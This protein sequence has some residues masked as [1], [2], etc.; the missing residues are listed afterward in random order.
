MSQRRIRWLGMIA[1]LAL[2]PAAWAQAP[3]IPGAPAAPAGIAAPTGAAPPAGGGGNL[4]SFFC[5]TPEQKANCKNCFCNS[6]LGQMASGFAGPMAAMSGGLMPNWCMQNSLANDL[7][8]PADSP[9]GAAAQVK[10]DEAEAQE[11][12]AVAYLGTVDCERWPEA[13]EALKNALRKDRSECVRFAAALALRRGC[14]CNNEI[15]EALKNCVLGEAKTDPNPVERSERVRNAAAEALSRCVTVQPAD[16]PAEMQ[17]KVQAAPP[18]PEDYY[19]KVAKMPHDEVVASARAALVSMQ[20]PAKTTPG[21]APTAIAAPAAAPVVYHPTSISG[22]VAN[23][24][25]PA[26]DPQTRPPF[27][28]GLTKALTG[29]QEV[30]V[31]VRTEPPMSGPIIIQRE[32]PPEAP[33]VRTAAGTAADPDTRLPGGQ[34][35]SHGAPDAAAGDSGGAN[36]AGT[37]RL[38]GGQPESHSAP[39][40][41]AGDSGG[42]NGAGTARLP[43][44]QPESHGAPDAA[45]GD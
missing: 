42:A 44:G 40:A 34:A 38:P 17:Q 14:C 37:A 35:D 25:G 45:A 11:R 9:G 19:K 18:N 39:D 6:P 4:W 12:A 8:K 3:A 43:G 32:P 1:C 41:A 33:E 2:T 27:F 15:I 7:K 10:K 16:R 22:I 31:P 5:L 24:F 26:A 23:A 29:K 21:T 30:G 13:V 28:S 36:G 20:K